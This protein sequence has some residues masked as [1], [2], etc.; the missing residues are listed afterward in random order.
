[1]PL[2]LGLLLPGGAAVIGAWDG[3]EVGSQE[4][5]MLPI[6]IGP[7]LELRQIGGERPVRG[8]DGE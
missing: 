5:I 6:G 2:F 7:L 8:W 4:R 3:G 1:M